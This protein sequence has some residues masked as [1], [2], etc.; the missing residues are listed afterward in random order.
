MFEIFFQE[1]YIDSTKN[2]A[3]KKVLKTSLQY[4][5]NRTFTDEFNMK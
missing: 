5:K 1:K 3:F 4:E 2:I